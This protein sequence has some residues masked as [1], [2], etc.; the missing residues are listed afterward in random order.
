MKKVFFISFLLA[1]TVVFSQDADSDGIDDSYD[2]CPSIANPN[3]EDSDATRGASIISQGRSVWGDC[4]GSP[5][6]G[7]PSRVVDGSWLQNNGTYWVGLVSSGVSTITIDLGAVY[8]I[9][10]ISMRNGAD[11]GSNNAAVGS[12]QFQFSTNNSTW[13]T[14]T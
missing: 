1:S 14:V 6:W 10:K 9:S 11:G 8:D 3:Q 13:T 7:P 5:C 2:N 4:G 12:Y